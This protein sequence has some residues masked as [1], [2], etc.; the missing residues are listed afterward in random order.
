MICGY[1]FGQWILVCRVVS[2]VFS[3]A[4][5]DTMWTC[6]ITLASTLSGG[7]GKVTEGCSNLV[8]E[9]CRVDSRQWLNRFIL[10]RRWVLIRPSLVTGLGVRLRRV[11][12]VTRCC[13]RLVYCL[14]VVLKQAPICAPN[15]VYFIVTRTLNM[16]SSQQQMLLFSLMKKK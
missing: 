9:G 3:V 14:W 6:K 7:I 8:T 13:L 10:W 4:S 16:I 1:V 15:F 11:T 12:Y 2:C 5:E